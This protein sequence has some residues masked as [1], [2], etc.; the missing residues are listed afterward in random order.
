MST[1]RISTMTRTGKIYLL[2]LISV[3]LLFGGSVALA[4]HE[5]AS[6]K[7]TNDTM[8]DSAFARAADEANL[9]EVKL[10]QLAEEKGTTQ[11]IKDFGKRMVTDHSRAEDALRTA[12]AKDKVS[13]PG[14]LDA[15]D[16]ALYNSLSKLSG[17]A[18]DRAYQHDMIT[19]HEND[20]A[21]FRHE[22][23]DGK[24]AA[25]KTFASETLPTL[26]THLH[27]AKEMSQSPSAQKSSAGGN[28]RHSG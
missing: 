2:A 10:G 6:K 23:N 19:N 25:I 16:Q 4:R 12:A 9:T 8:S 13:L 7:A 28:S 21:A 11:T 1:E 27:L 18:F 5:A 26:E 17:N 3:A 22:A 14:S 20:I 15:N 24:D